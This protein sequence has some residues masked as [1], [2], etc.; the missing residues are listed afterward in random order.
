MKGNPTKL[1]FLSEGITSVKTVAGATV[2]DLP[3]PWRPYRPS[4]PSEFNKKNSFVVKA[5]EINVERMENIRRV[6]DSLAQMRR[7]KKWSHR[8]RI[9]SAIYTGQKCLVLLSSAAGTK[10]DFEGT[11]KRAQATRPG[12]CGDQAERS[13]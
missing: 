1:N 3:S 6:A 7:N 5:A 2:A 8:Y 4:S 11:A 13:L 12:Q 9:V 10:V